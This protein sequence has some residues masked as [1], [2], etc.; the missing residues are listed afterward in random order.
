MQHA[1]V[2]DLVAC[3][4]S[5]SIIKQKPRDGKGSDKKCRAPKRVLGAQ[6]R[7]RAALVAAVGVGTQPLR[8]LPACSCGLAGARRPMPD[9]AATGRRAVR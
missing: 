9:T 7:A 3:R 5:N 2:A 1:N 8:R 6:A 4:R